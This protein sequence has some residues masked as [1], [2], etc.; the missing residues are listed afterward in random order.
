MASP[1]A[2]ADDVLTMRAVIATFASSEEAQAFA[3]AVRLRLGRDASTGTAGASGEPFDG[4]PL[5]VVWVPDE[6][7]PVARALAAESGGLI[8]DAPIRAIPPE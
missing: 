1:P 4:H 5:V 6:Q 7:L 2:W 8:H 3:T